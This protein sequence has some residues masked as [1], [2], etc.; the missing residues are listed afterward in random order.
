MISR[1]LA[2]LAFLLLPLTLHAAPLCSVGDSAQVFWKGKWYPASVMRV[3]ETQTK[4]FIRYKGYGS[5]WD[6]W[7][8]ADR[9]QVAGNA[10]PARPA[11]WAVGDEVLVQWQGKWYA[12]SIIG[13]KEGLY[14]IHYDGY[15]ASWDEWVEPKRIRNR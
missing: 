1:L 2:T 10:A 15:A 4:C 13:R 3:N 11:G 12:A 5:E 7:V 6:E 14:K 9:I 8:G